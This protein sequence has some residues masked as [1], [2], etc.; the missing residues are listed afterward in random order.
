[1]D[2]IKIDKNLLEIKI[3][4]LK[5]INKNIKNLIQNSSIEDLQSKG[6]CI[7]KTQEI[8]TTYNEVNVTLIEFMDAMISFLEHAKNTYEEFDNQ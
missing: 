8:H 2:T 6:L 7:I 3:E 4:H 5:E 1:M